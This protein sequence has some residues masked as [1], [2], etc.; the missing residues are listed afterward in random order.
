MRSGNNVPDPLHLVDDSLYAE[1]VNG[2]DYDDSGN[3]YYG[4]SLCGRSSTEVSSTFECELTSQ[5][6]TETTLS[7]TPSYVAVMDNGG[8]RIA[9][10]LFH[11]GYGDRIDEIIVLENGDVLVAGGFCWLSN[12]CYF[13]GDNMLLEAPGR[14]LDAFIFRMDPSG[15][16]SWARAFWSDGNDLIHSLDEGPN[17]EIYLQ[18]T[19]CDVGTSQCRLNSVEGVQGPLSKGGADIFIAKLSSDGS[20]N[21]VKT[22]GSSTEDHTLGGGYWSLQQMGIVATSDSG[23][24]V[25][26]SVSHD[27]TFLDTCAFRLSLIHISEPTRPS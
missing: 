22:L 13:Q 20:I 1:T 5:S 8:N 6:G 10:H 14:N 21:W 3:L 25:T 26:G 23:V 4:G 12:E 19:F 17:G 11:S 18:G 2:M 7:F 16:V 27:S 15:E 24:L 9:A